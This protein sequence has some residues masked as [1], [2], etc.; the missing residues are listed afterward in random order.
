MKNK[1]DMMCK[2]FSIENTFTSR[3][4]ITLIVRTMHAEKFRT[5]P[6][7]K[8]EALDPLSGLTVQSVQCEFNFDVTITQQSATLA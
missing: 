6:N 8:P 3:F 4:K 7:T 1:F 5:P 2:I